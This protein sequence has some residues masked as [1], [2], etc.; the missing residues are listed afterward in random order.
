MLTAERYILVNNG[1]LKNS[2]RRRSVE[3]Y[4]WICKIDSLCL[5]FWKAGYIWP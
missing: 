1:I 4:V 3:Y 5:R 2:Y